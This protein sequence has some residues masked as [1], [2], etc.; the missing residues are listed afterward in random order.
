MKH[1]DV[2]VIGGG[3]SGLMAA[4]SAKRERPALSVAVIEGG[5]R[6]GKKLLTTGNGRCNL[7]NAK[8][9][10]SRY[11][12]GDLSAVGTVLNRLDRDATEAFFLSLGIPMR[13]EE[14]GKRYP[15]SLQ[16]ASVVDA[17]RF[18]CAESGA[19][20][21]TDRKILRLTE[22]GAA[23]EAER[24]DSYAT[25]VACGG[26]SAVNTGSDGSG[27]RLLREAG[28]SC[29]ELH[30]AITPVR[31]QTEPIRAMKGVK[32][33]AAVTASAGGETR[34]DF[35]EVL[36]T[37]YGLSGPPILQLS[38]FIASQGGAA[39]TL[40]LLPEKSRDWLFKYLMSRKGRVF[41]DAAENL[42]LG[43][44]PKRVGMAVIK[45]CGVGVN[46]SCA[47]LEKR[48]IA[49]LTDAV[50]AFSLA[51]TGVCGYDMAQVTAGGVPLCEF[52]DDLMSKKRNG[53]FAC[54][55]VLDVYGD[56][57]G[58]NLQWAWSSGFVAGTAAARYAEGCL[59]C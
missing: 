24:Y 56:C 29:T 15:Y 51:A 31:T 8:V 23:C 21:L 25:V 37:D 1:Y 2:L 54:G 55:E 18:A 50:K 49:A 47:A 3:A 5:P 42:F 28:H 34:A 44:L 32:I 48:S 57:G 27:F 11:H 13:E 19:E 4:I 53:L 58:F 12:S 22:H 10:L 33:T 46:D 52:T 26:K 35:G 41:G 38:G 45:R 40:D 30:P 36:F 14:S 20:I 16:A 9:E 59:C 7:T 6:V 39:L 17:L 43:L